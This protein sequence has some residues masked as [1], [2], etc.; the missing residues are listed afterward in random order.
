MAVI[1]C[2]ECDKEISSK[3]KSCPNCGAVLKKKTSLI[4]WLFLVLI[5]ALAISSVTDEKSTNVKSS[6]STNSDTEKGQTSTPGKTES[7]KDP[8]WSTFSSSDE[9]TGSI[10]YYASGYRTIPNKQ[11]GFPYGDVSARLGVG[12]D[13]ADHWVY[14]AFNDS[15]NFAKD[16]TKSGYNLIVT[17]MKFDENLERHE[18]TQE[19]GSKFVHFSMGEEV[20]EKIKASNLLS[21]EFQWHGEQPVLFKFDLKGSAKAIN[22][23]S[24][25]CSALPQ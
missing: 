22:Q 9:M 21:V 19:W 8:E 12:C 16:E 4:T 20:V 2:K 25:Q 10:S 14:I 17:R 1:K 6:Q 18:F 11:M 7:K 5:I 13:K 23:I 15:P 24:S 3:A